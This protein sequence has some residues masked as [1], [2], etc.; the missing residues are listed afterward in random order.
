VPLPQLAD[1]RVPRQV[2]AATAQET[3][4]TLLPPP[5][6]KLPPTDSYQRTA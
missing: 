2:Q 4:Q 6:Q 3:V 5:C 1:R